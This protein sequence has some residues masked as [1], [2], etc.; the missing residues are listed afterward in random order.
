MSNVRQYKLLIIGG[1]AGSLSVILKIV[2]KLTS[3]S[4]LAVLIV[5][6]RKQADESV[7][8]DV[9]S[10]RTS[11]KVKEA[12]DKDEL[13]PGCI[14]ISPPDYHVL[15]E[16]NNT[17]SLDDSERINYSRPSIDATFESAAEAF[18]EDLICLLLSGANADGVLGLKQVKKRG[19]TVLVQ[20]PETAEVPYMPH[21]AVRVVE[22]DGLV[23]GF[24]PVQLFS[25]L[26]P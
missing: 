15:V 10:A 2:A 1:S 3:K 7:L 16:K 9:V 18:K 4:N 19:G 20:D 22:H 8:I 11:F 14:Y 26:T 13:V 5:V 12:E 17:I 25:F 23:S 6:H 21:E 24:D